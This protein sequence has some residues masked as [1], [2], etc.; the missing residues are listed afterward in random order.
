M[1]NKLEPIKNN[2]DDANA[3]T[4]KKLGFLNKLSLDAKETL[5]E[6]KELDKEIDYIKLVC[7][8]KNG[9]IFDIFRGVGDFT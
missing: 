9:N 7:V 2:I 3:N 6:I 5:D 1:K 8:H 4:F